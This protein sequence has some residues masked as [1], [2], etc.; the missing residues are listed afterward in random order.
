MHLGTF[1][2]G[3]AVRDASYLLSL[4]IWYSRSA[5]HCLLCVSPSPS[6]L[7]CSLS[8]V[9]PRLPATNYKETSD[10]VDTRVWRA[11]VYCASLLTRYHAY[12]LK[13]EKSLMYSPIKA[14]R[15]SC[16]RILMYLLK[17]LKKEDKLLRTI[18]RELQAYDPEER[19]SLLDWDSWFA[20]QSSD[21]VKVLKDGERKASRPRQ[22]IMED[23]GGE[24][25]EAPNAK[26]QRLTVLN[27]N[28]R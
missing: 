19:L 24:R 28:E 9:L 8:Q 22:D 16:G 4:F 17:G 20:A 11:T 13:F 12:P 14:D 3:T 5:S 7:S 1:V 21:V 27:K 26:K 2:C 15:W 18:G 23:D 25:M 6:P 10:S